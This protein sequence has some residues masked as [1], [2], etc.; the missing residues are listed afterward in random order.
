MSSQRT[1]VIDFEQTGPFSLLLK[2]ND[3]FSREIDFLPALKGDF[4]RPLR[5]PEYFKQVKLNTEVGTIEWPNEMDFHPKTLRDWPRHLEAFRN[6]H[7]V[8]T[9]DA[10]ALAAA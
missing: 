3:G 6:W 2:F 5:Q 10:P 8:E 1:R 9:P 7:P 4:C